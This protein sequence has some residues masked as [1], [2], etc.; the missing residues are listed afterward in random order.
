MPRRKA[1]KTHPTIEEKFVKGV[2]D[3][4]CEG[5]HLDIETIKLR[6]HPFVIT[7]NTEF[8]SYVLA[9]FKTRW[10]RDT[11]IRYL[12]HCIDRRRDVLHRAASNKKRAKKGFEI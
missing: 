3:G 12:Y 11:V 1:Y 9:A 4:Y 10:T 5:Y 2:L 7:L 8:F 6:E